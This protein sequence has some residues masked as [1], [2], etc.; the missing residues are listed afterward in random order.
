MIMSRV[1]EIVVVDLVEE[2]EKSG[3]CGPFPDILLI[4]AK[5]Q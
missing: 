3:Y 4:G 2:E 1:L 5:R